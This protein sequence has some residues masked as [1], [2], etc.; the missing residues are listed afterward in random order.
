MCE[1]SSQF[2]AR[3]TSNLFQGPPWVRTLVID[4]DTGALA[5]PGQ[6]GLLTHFR[7]DVRDELAVLC[8]GH[9]EPLP[10]P[11]LGSHAGDRSGYGRI[12]R[13]RPAWIADPFQI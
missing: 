5:G 12:G 7:S 8:A 1:M 3:G 9:V 11:A 10:G 2:Y 6:P 4:P 13:P